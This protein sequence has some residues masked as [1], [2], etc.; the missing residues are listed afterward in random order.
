MK[1]LIA[2]LTGTPLARMVARAAVVGIGAAYVVLN[3][4]DD[5]T[6]TAVWK[7]AAAAGL[8]AA[9]NVLTP[10]NNVLGLFKK[11]DG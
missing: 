3:N 2:R 8:Y 4:S 9:L 11:S 7:G 5:P 10:L 6:N 1:K